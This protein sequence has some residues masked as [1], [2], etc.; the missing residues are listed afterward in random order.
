MKKVEALGHKDC[1]PNEISYI[2]AINA[3]SNSGHPDADREIAAL[4]KEM[5]KLAAT[6]M[7]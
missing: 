1:G 2:S 5:K 7:K 6:K 4:R 3:W